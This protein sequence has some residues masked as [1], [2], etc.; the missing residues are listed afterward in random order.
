MNVILDD[1]GINR[2]V[3]GRH[4]VFVYNRH[5]VYIGRA[6]EKYGEFSELETQLL[7]GLCRPGDVIVEV[8]ANIG[9]ITVPLANRV[10]AAGRVL[11]FE[12]Q[13]LV[14]QMLCANVALNSLCNVECIPAAVGRQ[15]DEVY[16]P[17]LRYDRPN[18]FGGVSLTT[19]PS[20][21]KVRCVTL[22]EFLDLPALRL[23]KIDVEGMERLVLEG[24]R[25]T[26]R[27]FRPALFVENDRLDRS[28]EL[29][30]CIMALDYDLF[31]HVVPMFNP[32]NYAGEAENSFGKIASWNMLCVPRDRPAQITGLPRIDDPAEHPLR[33]G[34]TS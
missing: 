33:K 8:G 29:I 9:A 20:G 28:Q 5:D 7:Q 18:N 19:T 25:E 26:I 32:D 13:P 23:L 24:A 31:W 10:G 6:L 16:V 30:E 21:T 17:K 34:D 14:F 3:R 4:G 22:D 12:P 2:V 11:A 15:E 27:H 1:G